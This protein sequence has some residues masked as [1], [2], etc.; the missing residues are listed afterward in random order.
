MLFLL[1]VSWGI[2]LF[3]EFTHVYSS[4]HYNLSSVMIPNPTHT[5]PQLPLPA[6]HT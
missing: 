5:H 6:P 1:N 3:S 2:L 4:L